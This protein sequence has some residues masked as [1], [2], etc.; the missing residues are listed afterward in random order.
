M[1]GDGP[2]RY[3]LENLTRELNANVIFTGRLEGDALNV[4]YNIAHVF[5]LASYQE[6]FGAVTNEALL[7][8]CYALISNKAGSSCLVEEGEN[9]YTFSPMDVDELTDKMKRL[10]ELTNSVDK[11]VL[12]PNHMRVSYKE[13]MVDLVKY[14]KGIIAS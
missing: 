3:S 4:W 10:V 9:G 1:V 5:I 11:V 2:E 13:K 6:A 8:G 7:A 14:L 12:K